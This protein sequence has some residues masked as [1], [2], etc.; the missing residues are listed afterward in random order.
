M[1]ATVN[2]LIVIHYG[3]LASRRKILAHDGDVTERTAENWL[4][5]L[6]EPRACKLKR[7]AQSNPKF[8]ADLIAWLQQDTV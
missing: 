2:D 1:S 3:P 5:R 4:A 6:C 7:I 8:R